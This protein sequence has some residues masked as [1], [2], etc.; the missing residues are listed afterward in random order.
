MD[1]DIR[2][3]LKAAPRKRE[4]KPLA[5]LTTVWGDSL[6]PAH[7]LPGHPRPQLEREEWT[8]LNGWWNCAFVACEDAAERWHD[9]EPP[10]EF[11]QRILVPFSPEASLSGVG[12]QLMPNELLWYRRRLPV[13]VVRPGCRVILHFEAVDWACSV[14]VNGTKV[15]EHVGGYLPFS[16]DVTD[17]YAQNHS[18]M[19][20][21]CVFDPSEE[22][23]QLRGKQRIDRGTMWYTA[24]SGIWQTAWLEVVPERHVKSLRMVADPDAGMLTVSAS[25][26]GGGEEL[27]VLAF[28]GSGRLVA[29]GGRRAG[30]D[31]EEVTVAV[32]M[33]S[34]HLWTPDDPY[35]YQLRIG[36]GAD[37]VR[38]YCAFRTTTVEPDASG[39]MRFCLNHKPLFLR[40]VL[41]QSYWPDGLL[42]AP[43]DEAIEY[44]IRSMRDAGF[45]MMRLHIKLESERWYWQCDRMGMLVWQDMVSGGG[46]L[47]AW[48]TQNKPTLFR[49]SWDSMRDD[50]PRN[51]TK[52]AAGDPRYREEWASTCHA[53][54][55]RLSNHPCVVTW[56]LF[57]ESWG[58]FDS[59]AATGRVWRID[60]TRPV[61][62][63][64]GWY[65]QG[66]GDYRGVHN[67]FRSMRVYDDNK[68]GCAGAGRAF[69][70]SEFGGLVWSVAGHSSLDDEYGYA[71]YDS[72]ESWGAALRK[73]LAQ[74]DALE[75]D[76][77]AGFVYTQVSDVEEETNGLLT[78]DRRVN[79]AARWLGTGV[80]AAGE[81]LS[82]DAVVTQ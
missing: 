21:M 51:Q 59:V 11:D 14:F 49:R 54:V 45:N 47:S 53:A 44:D 82:G 29:S 9:P 74:V 5:P 62:S 35:L 43:S 58:Q 17:V 66:S 72:F 67:Y 39:V 24:Q 13:V 52:L 77:L 80:A 79:K 37:V 22:G 12:R 63:V 4:K 10:A 78:Y 27:S 48:Q 69:V 60:P 6:D 19:L 18:N 7:V 56:V 64:S 31:D 65:D 73:L 55:R 46:P 1:L 33:P 32:P 38:S 28:D 42:T 15:G 57:N 70:I 16:F 61:L 3:V 40:G 68:G 8:S 23:V 36:Y 25:V 75:K 41:N 2:R 20:S 26:S 50:T 71:T 81:G 34:P 76:G 30:E